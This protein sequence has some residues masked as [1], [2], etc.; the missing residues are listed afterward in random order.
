VVEATAGNTGIGLAMAATLKGYKCIFTVP[1]KMSTEKVKLLKAFGA[2]V[3]VTPTAVSP[4]SPENYVNA[5]KRIVEET[6]NA[7]LANQFANPENPEA[8][9]RTT[10][11]EVW[12]QTGGR[13]DVFVCGAG[14]GG[15]ISGVGRYLKERDPNV[16]VVA[17]DPY[18]SGLKEY[19]ESERMGKSSV[20]LVEGIGSDKLYETLHLEYVD[21]FRNVTDRES[22]LI[23]RRLT[24]EEGLLVGGS[25]GTIVHVALQ[26]ARE[27]NDAER[28]VVCVL[29][30]SGERYLSKFHSDE[31]M[32]EKRML[33]TD[34]VSVQVLLDAKPPAFSGVISAEGSITGR[35]ALELMSKHNVSQLPIIENG[36]SV[37]SISEGRLM[38]A[39]LQNASLLDAPVEPSMAAPFPV[40]S[41]QDTIE[42]VTRL[43]TRGNGAVL[44]R[45]AGRIFGIISRYDIVHFLTQRQ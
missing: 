9:Y 4:D 41:Y 3:V 17:A 19:F 6:P 18:G 32:R 20:Y 21:E 7:V 33:E 36:E 31:W 42:H 28:V 24:R 45:R 30:D 34:K 23:A 15:T 26:I 2:E 12:E 13:I 25:S 27:L 11:P 10:G 43:L 16:R 14:T 40:V 29:P 5:A 22:F 44:A 39:V 8:H 38:T 35:R 37:G 1:D